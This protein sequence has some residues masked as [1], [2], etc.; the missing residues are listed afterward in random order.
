MRAIREAYPIEFPWDP[1]KLHEKDML[2]QR[3]WGSNFQG[4]APSTAGR[5]GSRSRLR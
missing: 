2:M 3:K 1:E 4:C 5:V